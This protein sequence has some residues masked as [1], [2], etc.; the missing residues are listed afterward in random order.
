MMMTSHRQIASNSTYGVFFSQRNLLLEEVGDGLVI[1][2]I[3]FD[4]VVV[5]DRRIEKETL[6]WQK[7][8]KGR[9]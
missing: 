5:V 9:I 6:L 1:Y 4:G 8:T 2:E 7:E 3:H